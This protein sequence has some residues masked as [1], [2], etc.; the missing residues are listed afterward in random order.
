MIRAGPE[1][2]SARCTGP[3]TSMVADHM[4]ADRKRWGGGAQRPA[5]SRPAPT[6]PPTGRPSAPGPP[7]PGIGDPDVAEHLDLTGEAGVPRRGD[8]GGDGWMHLEGEQ[9]LAGDPAHLLDGGIAEAGIG[10]RRARPGARAWRGSRARLGA[11]GPG[12]EDQVD[13]VTATRLD[14]LADQGEAADLGLQT[15]LLAQLAAGGLDQGLPSL[16]PAPGEQPVPVAT[17][18][19]PYQEEPVP[20]GNADGD[21]NPRLHGPISATH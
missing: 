5:G 4:G 17:L 16:H 3:S 13:E 10:R 14:G 8:G 9:L 21:S 1:P 6:R 19:V 18:P 15:G 7:A 20:P 12:G 2:H 11:G